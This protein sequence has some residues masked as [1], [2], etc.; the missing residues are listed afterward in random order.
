MVLTVVKYG[1]PT[2]R[3][4][5]AL[6][7]N[8]TP[9][10]IQLI[11]E[12]FETMYAAKGVGL[13]AQQVGRALQLTVIDVRGLK[14]RPSR[15]WL[16]GEEVSPETLMPLTLIN[17]VLKPVGS[18]VRGPEGCLSFP[19]LYAEIERPSEVWVSALNA[20]G[21][22]IE[23]RAGGLLSRAIQHE[24]GTRMLS[25]GVTETLPALSPRTT[26]PAETSA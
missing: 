13:A 20:Q 16:N 12:M 19:E 23:F 15:A 10:I 6:I 4:K 11:D 7:G 18:R 25:P 3:K 1:N 5:G 17:P 24:T 21:Q 2:L 22:P 26:R 8:V 9:E 14:D